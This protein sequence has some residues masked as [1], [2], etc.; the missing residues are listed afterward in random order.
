MGRKA[1]K[2]QEHC[3]V[4]I[5]SENKEQE[6]EMD[7][8]GNEQ[9]KGG[10]E[11]ERNLL[12]ASL[13]SPG[14]P[15]CILSIHTVSACSLRHTPIVDKLFV[16]LPEG[17]PWASQKE[18]V[19]KKDSRIWAWVRSFGGG[20]KEMGPLLIGC[21]REWGAVHTEGVSGNPSMERG[22]QSE[23]KGTIGK[24]G[25]SCFSA[26]GGSVVLVAAQ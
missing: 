16:T 13:P 5:K 18:G 21:C 7:Q 10:L 26:K 11:R 6:L 17:E 22:D 4:K 23:D 12:S 8:P 15:V 3:V 24:E 9:S 19:R 2:T 25:Q 14:P 20:S 1:S